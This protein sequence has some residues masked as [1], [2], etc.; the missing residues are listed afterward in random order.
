MSVKHQ[1][2][3]LDI[4]D[5][6]DPSQREAVADAVIEHIRRRT[7]DGVDRNGQKFPPYSD[8]YVKSLAFKIAGKKRS[9]INL[10]LSGDMLAALELLD[11]KPGKITIGF[12]KGSEENARADGNIRGSYGGSPDPK[13]ARDF[14]GVDEKELEL[15]LERTV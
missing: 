8:I 15:I 5:D 2:I 4:P 13:K 12:V 9:E 6:L 10:T 3:T 14:L 7:A 11:H 1:R